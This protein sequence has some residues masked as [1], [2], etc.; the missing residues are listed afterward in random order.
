M[1]IRFDAKELER[2][3][4]RARQ[5]HPLEYLELLFGRV[6]DTLVDIVSIVPIKH[7][8]TLNSEGE[9]TLDYDT[10]DLAPLKEIAGK[11]GLEWIGTIHSHPDYEH[12]FASEQDNDSARDNGEKVFGIY[13]FTKSPKTGRCAHGKVGFFFPQRAIQQTS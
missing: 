3:K 8:A 9:R 13:S 5:A 11:S 4:K 2:F 6:T 12:F 7:V 1:E 10:K